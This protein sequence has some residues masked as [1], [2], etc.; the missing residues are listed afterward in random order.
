MRTTASLAMLTIALVIPLALAQDEPEPARRAAAVT[1]RA[2]VAG[3]LQVDAG[4][5][6]FLVTDPVRRQIAVYR[7]SGSSIHFVG[8]RD[9]DA[10]LASPS[11]QRRA[12]T[13]VPG[14]DSPGEDP[15]GFTRPKG[16]VRIHARY[17]GKVDRVEEWNASYLV[18]SSVEAVYAEIRDAHRDARLLLSEVNTYG[19]NPGARLEFAK[20]GSQFTVDLGT[21]DWAPEFHVRVNVNLRL[22][23]QD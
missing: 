13:Q 10:D 22:T 23:K 3:A 7:F 12:P 2:A 5:E 17:Q 11:G 19:Q 6:Y 14:S 8:A 4:P 15:P 1:P 21:G 9:L 16:A 18:G 20:G